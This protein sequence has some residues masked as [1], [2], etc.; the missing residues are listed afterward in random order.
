MNILL[1]RPHPGNEQFG[2]GPF[3]RTEPLGLEYIGAAL[4]ERGHRPTIADLRF[5]P[6]A[7]AWARR[8][9][10][11]LVGISCAHALEYDR[12][13]ETASE[14]R[15][16]SPGSFILVGGHAAASY[17]SPLKRDEIDAICLDDGEE[18]TAEVADAL[19][20]GSSLTEIPGLLLRTKDAWVSTQP[21]AE[22]VSL[23]R[24]GLPARDLV[25]RHRSGYY[26]LLFKPVWLIETTRGCPYR[27]SFCSVWQL[28]GRTFRERS[29]TNV[30]EDF[31][32]T[33]P[34]IFVADDLFWHPP[35]R[36][37]ELA[38]E[39]L[40]RKIFKRWI[41][42]QTRTDI[43]R[44][45][46]AV[47]EA[48]RP[49]A[50]DFDIFLGLE[51]ASDEGLAHVD[52]D[53]GI[54]ES[55]EAVKIARSMRFG[56]NGNF[57]VDPDWTERDFRDLWDFVALHGLQR[58]GYTIVTPL[59]GTALFRKLE[60]RIRGNSWHRFDMHH[61]LWEPRLGAKRFFELYAKTWHLSVLNT[62]G[63]KSWI[64]W[65][66]Q[67]RP[68]QVPYLARILWRTQKIM[69]ARAYLEEYNA[70]VAQ[71]SAIEGGMFPCVGE[72]GADNPCQTSTEGRK[73]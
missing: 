54:G 53:A 8:T 37:I 69:D 68:L 59:P 67:V 27:C 29:I 72:V 25:D 38:K 73:K 56:V 36:S 19:E 12:V 66:R 58:A 2:L 35:E 28:Y 44:Q 4:R 5:R 20:R 62:S 13:L 71:R 46:P 60:P 21:I 10:P 63:Q 47:L 16:E 14:I 33:G 7:G 26:C 49:L 45:N 3:F 61:V 48:W 11:R 40:R 23:D 43:I 18:S 6:S 17:S 42:V 70:D 15:R 64:D 34:S 51:A 55:V 50:Q 32:S 41:L 22:R 65:L 1:L 31:A 9:R 30:V 24:V 39:L 52:K 57:L